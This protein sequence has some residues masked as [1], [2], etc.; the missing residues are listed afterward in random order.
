MEVLRR[1]HLYAPLL[2]KRIAGAWTELMGK[3]VA[4]YTTDISFKNRVLYLKISSSV[5]RHELFL[6][7]TQIKNKLNQYVKQDYVKDVILR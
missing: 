3:T 1:Q 4:C 2:E 7:R 5:L 6:Q